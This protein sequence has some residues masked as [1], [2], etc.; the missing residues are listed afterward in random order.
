MEQRIERVVARALPIP[1]ALPSV[2][3][4]IALTMALVGAVILVQLSGVAAAGYDLRRLQQERTNWERENQLLESYVADLQSLERVERVAVERLKMVPTKDRIFLVASRPPL[5]KPVPEELPPAP[6]EAVATA[7]E[8]DLQ[9]RIARW[10]AGWL[11]LTPPES[12]Q[13]L[14]Q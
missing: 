7:S 8:E 12:A 3:P 2:L 10:L 6:Q 5:T 13:R 1:I 4:L 11:A 9:L 14:V